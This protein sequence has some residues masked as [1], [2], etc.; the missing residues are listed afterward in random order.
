LSNHLQLMSGNANNGRLY[1]AVTQQLVPQPNDN[2]IP[3]LNSQKFFL[4][5]PVGT[6]SDQGASFANYLLRFCY[7]FLVR[8]A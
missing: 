8:P 7:A 4:L 6:A 3:S 5:M 2:R 1:C